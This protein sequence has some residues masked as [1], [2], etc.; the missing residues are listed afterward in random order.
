MM[1]ATRAFFVGLAVVLCIS[2][3]NGPAFAQT[4]DQSQLSANTG[5]PFSY[6][7][8]YYPA[9]QSF[10]AGLGGLLSRIDVVSN[11]QIS[12]GS[13]TVTL[14][15]WS[16][17]GTNG[18]VLGTITQTVTN[19]LAYDVP[20]NWLVSLD[21]SSLGVNE[22]AGNVYT[23]A[24]TDV[25][26]GPG[27]L[28]TRGIVAATNNPYADGRAYS[29]LYGDTTAPWDVEFRTWVVVP[30]PSTY[31]LLALGILALLGTRRLCRR[32]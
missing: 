14:S 22:T 11:G 30:E 10:T 31:S 18:L 24:F 32:S 23:F 27:D 7:A 3:C 25:S 16:G 21:V 20:G 12:G 2:L 15:I 19:T 8:E 13:N 29:A 9:G 5:I 17:D 4:V 26:G 6:G 1:Q 28:A